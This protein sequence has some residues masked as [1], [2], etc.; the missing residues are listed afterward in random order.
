MSNPGLLNRWLVPPVRKIPDQ[1]AGRMQGSGRLQHRVEIQ[2]RS[3][4]RLGPFP[5]SLFV[6]PAL[7]AGRF[8]NNAG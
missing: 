2:K 8:A 1:D 6:K 7:F 3:L 5:S 4:I